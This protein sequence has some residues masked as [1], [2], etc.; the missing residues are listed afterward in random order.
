MEWPI[1][2]INDVLNSSCPALFLFLSVLR[3]FSISF[4]S[5]GDRNIELGFLCFLLLR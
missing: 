3:I 4:A 5:V 2:F 1:D